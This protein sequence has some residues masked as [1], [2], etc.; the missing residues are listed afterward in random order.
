MKKVQGPFE[1]QKR[2]QCQKPC[3]EEMDGELT[4][5]S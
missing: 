5:F 3:W 1:P 2:L 4:E